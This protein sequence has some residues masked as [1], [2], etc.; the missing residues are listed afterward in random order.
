MSAYG[1]KVATYL[2]DRNG[3]KYEV[4]QEEP[5]TGKFISKW[6]EKRRN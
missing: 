4:N 2:Q 5:Y 6:S 1:E 3:V